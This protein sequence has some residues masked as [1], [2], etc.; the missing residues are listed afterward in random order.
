MWAKLRSCHPPTANEASSESTTSRPSRSRNRSRAVGWAR[1]ITSADCDPFGSFTRSRA[2]TS[3]LGARLA[4]QVGEEA[5]VQ[6]PPQAGQ[7]DVGVLRGEEPVCGLSSATLRRVK[8]LDVEVLGAIAGLVREERAEVVA[9]RRLVHRPRSRDAASAILAQPGA[10]A[11]RRPEQPD[12][13]RLDALRIAARRSSR[14]SPRQPASLPR[15]EAVRV[16]GGHAGVVLGRRRV[17]R[18]SGYA[19]ADQVSPEDPPDQERLDAAASRCVRTA[20]APVGRRARR[21]PSGE[22]AAADDAA[23]APGACAR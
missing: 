15:P 12:H 7:P 11:A 22:R 19:E 6:Q 17:A 3:G 8:V 14:S 18:A 21:R 9:D 10:A 23:A 5:V 20:R 1:M 13:A 2:S 16:E 4:L